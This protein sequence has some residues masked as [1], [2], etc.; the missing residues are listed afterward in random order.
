MRSLKFAIFDMD[1]LLFDTERPSYIAMK[2]V[3]EN[4]F[5]YEFPLDNYKLMIGINGRQCD[6]VM[7]KLYGNDFSMN[8]IYEEYHHQFSNILQQEGLQIKKGAKDLL[9]FLDNKGVKKCIA[10]SSS[11]ETIQTYLSMAGLAGR[12]DFYIS[13]EEVRRGKPYPD[14][15][16]GACERGNEE[17]VNSL[18]LEDSLNGLRA[19]VGAGIDCIIVPDL[20]EPN[21]E[22]KKHACDIVP[23]LGRVI[24]I[25]EKERS[26]DI[27]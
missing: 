18:V 2:R 10:S 24:R 17:P 6:E 16:L 15:F 20:I 23:D 26:V 1:G 5:G 27:G 3:I 8:L 12:F 22:M 21:E 19:A 4:K 25:L 11:R 14:I 13:G 7:K 9:L